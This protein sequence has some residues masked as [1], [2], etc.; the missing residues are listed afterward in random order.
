MPVHW[1]LGIL[2]NDGNCW[3]CDYG[4]N[5]D[6]VMFQMNL[7]GYTLGMGYD[8]HAN[9]PTSLSVSPGTSYYGGQAVD[10]EQLDDVQ[11]WFWLAGRIDPEDVIQ[12]RV[13]RDEMVLNYGLYLVWRKQD[14]DYSTDPN[15]APTLGSTA[16]IW[17]GAFLERHAWTLMPDI[18]AKLRWKKLYLEFE[19]LIIAGKM[20]NA[21]DDIFPGPEDSYSIF[22][23][24]WVLR[25]SYKL[26]DD[27]LSFGLEVGMASGDEAEPA[28]ADIDR[29]R[30]TPLGLNADGSRIDSGLN[31]SH[32][33]LNE[34]R[35]NFD[36][37]V[38]LILFRELLG[39]VANAVY[40]KP[41]IQYLVVDSLGARLDMIYSMAHQPVAFPGNSRNLGVELDL[42]V[43]YRNVEDGFFAGLQY[44]V[45]FP[46]DALD[47]PGD[48]YGSSYADEAK[49]A[50]TLQARMIIKF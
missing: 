24:G 1:G 41:W 40:F 9:G 46:L 4:T 35:F 47:R 30:W 36:Y 31:E 33:D 13:A 32:R 15:L 17:G 16:S 21:S 11:Q 28:N 19:G 27:S 8:F 34:F 20:E 10:L 23:F 49:I 42:D 50:H 18:W 6:R 45:L 14:F 25:S 22:Q 29:R 39:T 12:D 2:A 5:A 48:I 38:D 37:H 43:F 26:L 3:D 44:G 7:A